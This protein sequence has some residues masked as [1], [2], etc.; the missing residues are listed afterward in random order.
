[1]SVSG[2]EMFADA[3]SRSAGMPEQAQVLPRLDLREVSSEPQSRPQHQMGKC[4][5]TRPQ[6]EMGPVLNRRPSEG[7][8]LQ[9]IG[10]SRGSDK[11]PASVLCNSR[12]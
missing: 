2:Q 4:L 7:A 1:V 9:S 8:A 6:G 3:Q 11:Q 10:P 12:D 5:G